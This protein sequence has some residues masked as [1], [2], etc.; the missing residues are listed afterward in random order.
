MVWYKPVLDAVPIF[1]K[2][3]PYEEF[4]ANY[5]EGQRERFDNA[6]NAA[7]ISQEDL[8]WFRERARREGGPIRTL[9][10]NENWCGDGI[11]NLALLGR[12]NAETGA[13]HIRV[14]YR[15]APENA[16]VV[17]KY[18]LTLG[19]KKL[20][21]F[22]FIDREGREMGRFASRP[23]EQEFARIQGDDEGVRRPYR[24]G[25]YVAAAIAEFKAALA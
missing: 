21:V 20:P 11:F 19:R 6:Y 2:G 16:E 13:F 7:Q 24:D 12:I 22:V 8:E 15:D 3:I 4:V 5:D 14:I 23:E 10:I 1:E 18:F 25:S 9:V 17:E